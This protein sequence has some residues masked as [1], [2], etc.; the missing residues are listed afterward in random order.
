[1]TALVKLLHLTFKQITIKPDMMT[2]VILNV[3]LLILFH[4]NKCKYAR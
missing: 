1:M 2:V 4:S 3:T